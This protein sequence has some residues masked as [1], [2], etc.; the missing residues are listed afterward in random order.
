MPNQFDSVS[1]RKK[2]N[3]YFEGHS[4]S[5]LIELEDGT[6]KTLGVILPTNKYLIFKTHVPERIEII[7]GKCSVQ[8]GDE[9][10]VRIFSSGETFYVPENSYFKIMTDEVIDYVCHLG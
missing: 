1:I 10:E 7:S 5:H 4:I 9:P 3:V 8:I 6:K 2:A